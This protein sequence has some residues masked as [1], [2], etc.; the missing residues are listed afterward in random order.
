M[1][2]IEPLAAKNSAPASAGFITAIVSKIRMTLNLYT[3][4]RY[5]RQPL[6]ACRP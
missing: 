2:R 4:W 6:R 1:A 5:R 3:R